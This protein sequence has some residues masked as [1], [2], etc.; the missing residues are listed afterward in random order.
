[1]YVKTLWVSVFFLLAAAAAVLLYEEKVSSPLPIAHYCR[2]AAHRI[3][4][5]KYSNR[6]LANDFILFHYFMQR[7]SWYAQHF[8]GV[9][10]LNGVL[11]A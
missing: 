8:G 1:M 11:V 5:C 10:Q 4:M 7:I 2:V 6:L 9:M 3:A